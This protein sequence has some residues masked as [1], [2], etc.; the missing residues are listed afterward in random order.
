MAKEAHEHIDRAEPFKA[1]SFRKAA[2]WIGGTW[3]VLTVMWWSED[4]RQG[5]DADWLVS[6]VCAGVLTLLINSAAF[7][8]GLVTGRRR[9]R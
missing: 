1:P 9:R 4:A 2:A 3:V 7:V 5:R 6:A 8:V